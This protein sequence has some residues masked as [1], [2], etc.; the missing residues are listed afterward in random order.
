MK[1]GKNMT[2]LTCFKAYDIRGRLGE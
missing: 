1:K 2:K